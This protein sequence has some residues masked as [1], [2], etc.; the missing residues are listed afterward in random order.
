MKTSLD[1]VFTYFQNIQLGGNVPETSL[2]PPR[3]GSQHQR[4]MERLSKRVRT[5]PNS[6]TALIDRTAR[7]KWPNHQT[8]SPARGS[9]GRQH[10]DRQQDGTALHFRCKFLLRAQRAGAG[11]V[12]RF[13][14]QSHGLGCLWQGIPPSGRGQRTGRA[15]RRS[16]SH[17][18]CQVSYVALGSPPS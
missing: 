14:S 13:P 18:P 17:L 16:Q 11:H 10:R 12:A 5:S 2:R 4:S 3:A 9:L 6:S 1:L 7:I 8:M 15:V